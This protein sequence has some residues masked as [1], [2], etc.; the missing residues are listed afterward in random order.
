MSTISYEGEIYYTDEFDEAS[1]FLDN[2]ENSNYNTIPWQLIPP[3]N[4]SEQV[5]MAIPVHRKY[6]V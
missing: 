1:S 6:F 2:D 5:V 4:T 3:R